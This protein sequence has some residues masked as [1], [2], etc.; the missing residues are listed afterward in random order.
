MERAFGHGPF[1]LVELVIG[2]SSHVFATCLPRWMNWPILQA[3]LEPITHSSH[4]GIQMMG[5]LNGVRLDRLLVRCYNGF[6]V[7]VSISAS[8]WVLGE[9]SQNAP[10]V[11]D[12]LHTAGSYPF[13]ERILRTIVYTGAAPSERR[14]IYFIFTDPVLGAI[15][16]VTVLRNSDLKQDACE[17]PE[18]QTE[19][20]QNSNRKRSYKRSST[21]NKTTT[22]TSQSSPSLLSST[23][24]QRET[25]QGP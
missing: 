9:L 7:Q 11:A 1:G 18:P 2:R 10:L 8:P 19:T 5:L 13:S 3:F 14:T 6:F 25:S 15:E 22:Q 16:G 24:S 23:T 21:R 17:N 20:F 4:Y 12:T